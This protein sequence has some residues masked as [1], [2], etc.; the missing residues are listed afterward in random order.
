[1]MNEILDIIG[2]AKESGPVNLIVVAVSKK[3]LPASWLALSICPLACGR[4]TGIKRLPIFPWSLNILW[5]WT[6]GL[7]YTMSFGILKWL[8][9]YLKIS[10]AL[11]KV[12]ET[13]GSEMRLILLENWS[14]TS[15]ITVLLWD[16]SKS[17]RKS[18]QHLT[19]DV[20]GSEVAQACLLGEYRER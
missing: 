10:L 3:K 9:I 11:L 12:E 8:N 1:M 15:I 6:G 14:M 16:A 19:R 2:P 18:R 20:K 7:D 17:A 5:R 13:S 4:F